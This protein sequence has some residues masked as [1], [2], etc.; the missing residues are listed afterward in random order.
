M[1]SPEQAIAVINERFGKHPQFRALHAK[2]IVCRGSFTATPQAAALSKAAHLQGAAVETIVRVS[3]GGGDPAVPDYA[4]DVRGL[5]VAFVLADG[6]RT[7]ISAQTVPRFPVP[8]A[9]AFLAMIKALTPG[10]QQ[11]WRLPAFLAR[12]PRAATSL[13]VNAKGAAAAPQLRERAVLRGARV[14][15][16]SRRTAADGRSGITGFRRPASNEFRA[17]RRRLPDPTTSVPSGGPGSR[18]SRSDSTCACRSRS[19]VTA[20]PIRR[21][22]GRHRGGW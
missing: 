11:A 14:H 13:P 3:N 4:P 10:V 16:G 19:R 17:G 8:S 6:S 9:E 5:A 20:P 21:R 2:G 15:L 7:V 1:V 18:R 22:S 12:N